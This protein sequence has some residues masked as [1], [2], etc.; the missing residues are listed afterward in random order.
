MICIFGFITYLI[1][2]AFSLFLKVCVK[3]IYTISIGLKKN[4]LCE[5]LFG[6]IRELWWHDPNDT[7]LWRSNFFSYNFQIPSI[8]FLANYKTPL[9]FKCNPLLFRW[10][11]VMFPFSIM[12]ICNIRK[13][14]WTYPIFIARCFESVLVIGWGITTC[15]VGNCSA[16]NNFNSNSLSTISIP[17]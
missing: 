16:I 12:S 1:S 3:R 11:P 14:D 2:N 9:P 17:S 4:I 15:V 5:K 13:C 10:L 6:D 7:F 8:K